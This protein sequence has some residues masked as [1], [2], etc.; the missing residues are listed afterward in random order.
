MS[1][2]T[3]T[4]V[5]AVVETAPGPSTST[6]PASSHT[7]SSAAD[8]VTLRLVPRRPQRKGVRW[9]NETVDNEGLGRKSSK[10]EWHVDWI[11]LPVSA[12]WQLPH[13]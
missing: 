12:A 11:G 10:S 4:S 5:A 9:T 8:R 7:G 6:G 3:S 2:A 13:V 1:V